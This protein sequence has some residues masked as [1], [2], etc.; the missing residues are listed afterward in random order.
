MRLDRFAAAI[1][2]T[3]GESHNM[4][5][6]DTYE[7]LTGHCELDEIVSDQ[8]PVHGMTIHLRLSKELPEGEGIALVIDREGFAALAALAKTMG[9]EE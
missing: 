9:W 4:I 5:H 1:S 6:V 8:S 7:R 2:G 3:E